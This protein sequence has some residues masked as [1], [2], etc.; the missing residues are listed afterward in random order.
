MHS[1]H[2]IWS[3]VARGEGDIGDLCVTHTGEDDCEWG[4]E[5]SLIRFKKVDD[6]GRAP[7]CVGDLKI[8]RW[9]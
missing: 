5:S 6:A 3:L 7:R 2:K 1:A 9:A 4:V 8:V